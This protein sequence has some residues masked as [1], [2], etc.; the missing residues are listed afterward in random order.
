[1]R[2]RGIRGWL[3]TVTLGILVILT[4][5]CGAQNS[6]N[7][8]S[9]ATDSSVQQS[10]AEDRPM[11][12]PPTLETDQVLNVV[13]S[14]LRWGRFSLISLSA[15]QGYDSNPTLQQSAAGSEFS[16]FNGQVVY[17][18]SHPDWELFLQYE[19][20]AFVTPRVTAKNLTGNGSDFRASRRL[21][22][23]WNLR[24][25]DRFTYSPNLQSSIQ[26]NSLAVNLGGGVTLLTPLLYSSQSLLLNTLE[27]SVTGHLSE[28]STLDFHADQSFVRL[29]GTVGQGAA[30]QTTTED[31]NSYG[32]GFTFN[33]ILSLRDTIN[34]GYDYRAQSSPVAAAGNVTYDI[35]SFGWS[36]VLAPGLRVSMSG[37]PGW[38]DPSSGRWR[39][40]AQG[41]LQVAK[42]GRTGGVALSFT[43][44]DQ[45]SGAIGNSF[46]NRYAVRL[47]RRFGTRW[48]VTAT[49]SYI[50]QQNYGSH[51]LTGEMG[52][53]ELS[54]FTSRNWSV[55]GQVRYLDTQ[56]TDRS[57]APQKAAIMG[58]RWSWVPEKP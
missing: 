47:D 7:S 12:S 20:S 58:V 41:S 19:P 21:S 36:H 32:A 6:G 51:N 3:L 43:R 23:N 33:R 5:R 17:S 28:H 31:T 14:P 35:L 27:G 9:D 8:L 37:G 44:S 18:L 22:A 48:K 30:A 29:S 39:T 26:G 34:L 16:A 40:T 10:G 1:M 11:P 4:G 46:N 42:E 13:T 15:F 53:L 2:F 50:Q 38:S 54:W 57:I 25:G 55:F 52:A 45:F 24:A 56:G 49:G